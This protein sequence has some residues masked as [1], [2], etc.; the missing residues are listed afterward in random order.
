MIQFLFH[1]LNVLT[2][3]C[4]TTDGIALTAA[5]STAIDPIT[6]TD[7]DVNEEVQLKCF[8]S[9][10]AGATVG[11]IAYNNAA[12]GDVVHLG[13]EVSDGAGSALNKH[14]VLRAYAFED[15][16]DETPC[17]SQLR[18]TVSCIGSNQLIL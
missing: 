15:A 9:E 13:I 3:D 7:V 11:Q 1:C 5:S 8:I 16:S 12:A 14:P 18:D 2:F 4:R 17:G 10:D 6:N